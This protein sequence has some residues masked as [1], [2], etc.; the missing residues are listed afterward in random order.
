MRELEYLLPTLE[1]PAGGLARLRLHIDH[2]S[3]RVP[4]YRALAWAAPLA[5]CV[6]VAVIW[7]PPWLARRQRTAALV[8]AVHRQMAAQTPV[9]GIDVEDGAAIELP[10]GQA[11]VRIYLVQ[12]FSRRPTVDA[13]KQRTNDRLQR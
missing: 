9:Q 8:S 5:A 7:L 11:N 12:S 6:A 2:R 1:P 13:R 4:W 3:A 10:S